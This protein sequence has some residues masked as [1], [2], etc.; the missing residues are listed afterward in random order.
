MSRALRLESWQHLHLWWPRGDWTPRPLCLA[1]GSTDSTHL[2]LRQMLPWVLNTRWGQEELCEEGSIN[3]KSV[4]SVFLSHCLSFQGWLSF[5]D[6]SDIVLEAPY[7]LSH[8]TLIMGLWER[9]YFPVLHLRKLGHRNF[10]FPEIISL[11][12]AGFSKAHISVL[13]GLG[14]G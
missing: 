10:N 3:E 11:A 14:V 12:G 7:V 1:P 2:R 9:S 6:V 5:I 8:W 4:S 13:S